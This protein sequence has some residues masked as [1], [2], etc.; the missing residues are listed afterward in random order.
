[1]LGFFSV[2]CQVVESFKTALFQAAK[3]DPTI[4]AQTT[5]RPSISTAPN[6]ALG[7]SG[8]FFEKRQEG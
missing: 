8:I 2:S 7:V 6:G 4:G 1:M 5:T 3:E